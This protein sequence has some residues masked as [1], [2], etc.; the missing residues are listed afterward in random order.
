MLSLLKYDIQFL[1]ESTFFWE[2]QYLSH[3]IFVNMNVS[4]MGRY[5]KILFYLFIYLIIIPASI[6]QLIKVLSHIA[7]HFH[8]LP[9]C[10]AGKAFYLYLREIWGPESLESDASSNLI[11]DPKAVLRG[12]I[13]AIKKLGRALFIFLKRIWLIN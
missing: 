5:S 6:L 7:L 10:E 11:L 2:R 1:W 4:G 3:K 9:S 13:F 12:S 8:L